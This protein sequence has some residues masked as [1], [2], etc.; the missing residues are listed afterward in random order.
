M[1]KE[2][3]KVTYVVAKKGVGK[4]VRRPANVTGRFKVVDPRMK[5]DQ[6]NQKAVGKGN[7]HKG[8]GGKTAP[9]N[10]RRKSR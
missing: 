8:K 9:K 4:R 6:R 3:E 5:K 2:K 7:K 10:A 1:K